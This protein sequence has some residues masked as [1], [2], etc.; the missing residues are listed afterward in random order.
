MSEYYKMIEIELHLSDEIGPINADAAQ[1]EQI[2]M[3]LAVNAR[4][5]MP[6]GGLLVI[7][8]SNTTLDSE[9]CAKHIEATP[10]PSVL[11]L[12]S[13]TGTGMDRKT[14]ERIFEPFFT[15]KASG[16]GTGLGLAMVY[17]IVNQHGGHV[18]CYS[19][20][21]AGTAFKIY[22][23]A[24]FSETVSHDKT[25][26]REIGT[27]NETILL[28]DDEEIVR[29]VGKELLEDFGYRVITA[30]GGKEA[31]LVYEVERDNIDLV[32]LDLMMPEMG[33]KECLEELLKINP[34]VKSLICSGYSANGAAKDAS[35]AG[36]SGFVG[37]PY[38]FNELLSEIRKILGRSCSGD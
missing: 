3:N 7:E 16:K 33:G 32:I 31:L 19:E 29:E 27:G 14:M 23:P 38:I 26:I 13:D 28:V 30:E 9:Y 34:S 11:L 5:A 10:G 21:G 4:D 18:T 37:K 6:E 17:G 24:L 25:E 22:F 20:I 1:I 15:T 36:A 12:V 8:T 2:I 35:R